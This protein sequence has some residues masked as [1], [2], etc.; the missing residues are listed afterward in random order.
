MSNTHRRLHI[1]SSIGSKDNNLELNRWGVTWRINP[2]RRIIQAICLGLFLYSFFYVAWPYAQVFSPTVI[3]DKEWL[4]LELFLWIDPLAGLST[5]IAARHFSIALLGLIGIA[6]LCLIWPRGFCGYIC[7]LGTLID[8]FDA[9]S[10]RHVKWLQPKRPGWWIHLRYY[11]LAA[12][13]ISSLFGV[14]LAGFFSAIPVLTRGLLFTGGRL[15]LAWLKNTGFW[16]PVGLAFCLSIILFAAIFLSGLFTNRFWCR[17][18]CPS[19]ALFSIFSHFRMHERK[20]LDHCVECGNCNEI[21]PFDA[22]YDDH[23][24]RGLDCTFCQTCGGVCP[25]EAIRFVSRNHD[26]NLKQKN[27]PQAHRLSR[28]ALI[29]SGACGAAVAVT[30]RYALAGPSKLLRPPGSVPEEQFLQLCIRCGACMQ[31]CPGQ[32]LKPAGLE[33]GFA[34]WWTPVVVPSHAGCHQDCN[35][36]TQACPT[37]A[38]RPLTIEQKRKTHIG[39]AVVDTQTCVAHTGENACRL[40]HEECEAAGYNAIEMKKIELPIGD[41]PP[42]VISDA[43]LEAMRFIEVPIVDPD[44]CVGCGLCEFRCGAQLVKQQKV[45]KQS[46]IVIIPE[47]EDRSY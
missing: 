20:V 19:G 22:V 39:L 13:L 21:C 9:L 41:I 27:G 35:F 14:L 7:P 5:S 28:R 16:H 34:A 25:V 31:V 17:Y 2:I 1:F 30:T 4:P 29:I 42:G 37:G 23:T 36:C 12:I 15:E 45:L 26:D 24:T 18:L 10:G 8:V 40:C 47:N 32:V 43:E 38:I 33:E 44:A 6:L 3:S 11:L 46:A